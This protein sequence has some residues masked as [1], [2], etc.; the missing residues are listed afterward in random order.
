M[1]QNKDIF[2]QDEGKKVSPVEE[3]LPTSLEE[4]NAVFQ[5][6]KGRKKKKRPQF[7]SIEIIGII[8]HK[9]R[10]VVTVICLLLLIA[11]PVGAYSVFHK[12]ESE[13]AQVTLPKDILTEAELKKW[14]DDPVDDTQVFFELNTLW[15]LGKG[16]DEVFIRLLNPPY[17]AFP[18]KVQI[19]LEEKPGEIL[20]ESELLEPGSIVEKVKLDPR[21]EK[22][23]H[24]VIVKYSFYEKGST[25]KIF[26]MHE[27]S[28][29]LTVED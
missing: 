22:G 29:E 27:V 28:A 9:R 20:Y 15:T 16:E 18:I 25:D 12:K 1:E 3:E 14:E 10:F 24:A 8:K 23:K 26:G 11:I 7:S 13:P 5:E 4:L 17:S 21:P 2:S 19:Y 6:R